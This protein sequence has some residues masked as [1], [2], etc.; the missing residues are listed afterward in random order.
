MS[1]IYSTVVLKNDGPIFRIILNVPERLNALSDQL[2][3]D[4][5]AALDECAS[6][7]EIRVLVLIGAGRGFC[8]GADLKTPQPADGLDQSETLRRRISDQFN[9]M[10]KKLLALPVPTIAAVNG[11]A[12]GG[13]FGLALACDLVVAAESAD[14]IL[15]FTPQL[16]LIPD[17]GA[18]W[19]AA[20]NLGRA[21]AMA[22]AFFG[23]RISAMEA[24]AQG[25]IWKAVP[26]ES[27]AQ[28]IDETASKLANGPTR[29][30]VANRHALD[31]A[32]TQS[33]HDQLDLEAEI[34]P[35]LLMTEDFAEGQRA[36]IEKRKPV[37]KGR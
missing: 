2:L 37:F 8:A 34:Q 13:G 28:V 21:R 32:H 9:P 1:V 26:D 16:G 6:S 27:F 33:L 30:Y 18:S 4:L 29:A 10:I 23:N 22:T 25:L 15:V 14:F 12:A 36:F 19:H 17:M 3:V 31:R 5:G 20:R 35:T 7:P 11:V 24:E